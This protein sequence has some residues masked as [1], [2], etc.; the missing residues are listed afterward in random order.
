[1]IFENNQIMVS[2]HLHLF[3]ECTLTEQEEYVFD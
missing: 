3:L 1:L 2:I